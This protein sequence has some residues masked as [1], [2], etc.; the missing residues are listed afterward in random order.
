MDLC[1]CQKK[2]NQVKRDAG[3]AQMVEHLPTKHEDIANDM[4]NFLGDGNF[5]RESV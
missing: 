3:V 1:L 2:K 4:H 5:K